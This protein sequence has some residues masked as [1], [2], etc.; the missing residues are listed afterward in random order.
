MVSSMHLEAEKRNTTKK[1]FLFY[2]FIGAARISLC[3]IQPKD[4]ILLCPKSNQYLL[5]P[6]R[7]VEEHHQLQDSLEKEQNVVNSLQNMVVIVEE[8]VQ[9]P[10]RLIS[11]ISKAFTAIVPGT[12]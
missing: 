11:W 12:F 7:C 4:I 2:V 6:F 1:H 5:E 10:G 3:C 9:D 8:G